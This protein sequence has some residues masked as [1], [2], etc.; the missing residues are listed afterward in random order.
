MPPTQALFDL[1]GIDL[2]LDLRDARL[3]EIRRLLGDDRELRV[4]R[5]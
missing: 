5:Q 3:E 2:E 1:Q 4:M